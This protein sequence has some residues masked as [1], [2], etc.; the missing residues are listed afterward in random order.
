VRRSESPP[1]SQDR[2]IEAFR[3]NDKTKQASRVAREERRESKG[4]EAKGA[5]R[6]RVTRG[7]GPIGR[8]HTASLPFPLPSTTG[9]ARSLYQR[10]P[11]FAVSLFL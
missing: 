6:H 8:R 11:I 3:L 4:G 1:G 10:S 9:A 7:P 2:L 5:T